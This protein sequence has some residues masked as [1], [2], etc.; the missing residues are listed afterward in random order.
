M[1]REVCML[2][3]PL[4]R[5]RF[6]GAD[7]GSHRIILPGSAVGPVFDPD[8][9]HLAILTAVPEH[10]RPVPVPAITNTPLPTSPH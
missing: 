9:R 7:T 6:P 8:T 5:M 10:R 1:F 4:K 2:G 3:P